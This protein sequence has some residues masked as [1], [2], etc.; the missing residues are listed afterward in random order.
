[1]TPVLDRSNL[2]KESLSVSVKECLLLIYIIRDLKF[3]SNSC[4]TIVDAVDHEE[5]RQL[6]ENFKAR[7]AVLIG[8]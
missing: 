4:T 3:S 2:F 5:P 6:D 8:F 7:N 1:M